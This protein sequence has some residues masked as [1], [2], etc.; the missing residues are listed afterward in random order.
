[1][2]VDL[3]HLLQGNGLHHAA[4]GEGDAVEEVYPLAMRRYVLQAHPLAR[5]VTPD[6]AVLGDG[7]DHRVEAHG[8]A[9]GILGI[10]E[11]A[12]GAGTVAHH[13]GGIAADDGDDLPV[14][15]Q[16]PVVAPGQ[17]LLHHGKGPPGLRRQRGFPKLPVVADGEMAA[18]REAGDIGFD[19]QRK[20]VGAGKAVRLPGVEEDLTPGVGNPVGGEHC[21]YLLLGAAAAAHLERVVAGAAMQEMA[22]DGAVEDAFEALHS[23][24]FR[25]SMGQ[26]IGFRG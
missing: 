26:K 16:Y 17:V 5:Q 8:L 6:T 3:G 14:T 25:S 10:D 4:G 2:P 21:A 19:H 20:A 13:E 23:R 18:P 9:G 11:L 15:H 12:D 24:V 7:V 22:F 1:M